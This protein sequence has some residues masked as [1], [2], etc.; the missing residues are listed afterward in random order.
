M[1][2]DKRVETGQSKATAQAAGI[3][4]GENW[5]AHRRAGLLVDSMRRRRTITGITPNGERVKIKVAHSMPMDG[6]MLHIPQ[7]TEAEKVNMLM[8]RPRTSCI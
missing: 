7:P 5:A 4:L 6:G 2:M 3:I 8:P 1:S